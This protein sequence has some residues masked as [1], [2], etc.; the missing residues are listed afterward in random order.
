MSPTKRRA[1]TSIQSIQR[2]VAIL[3][4]FT[5]TAPELGVTPLS[6]QLGL[7]KS[8]VSRLLSALKHEGFVEQNPDTGKYRLS[9]GLVSLAGAALSHMDLRRAA[10]PHLTCLAALTQE[11][12]N[13][14][15]LEG[16]GCVNIDGIAS[17]KLI[18]YV[19]GLGRRT[20]LHCTAAGKVLLAH[21]TPEER[22]AILP[23]T[24]PRFTEK[25][26]TDYD[27]LESCLAE[28]RRQGYAI[29]HEELEEGL[30]SVAAPIHDHTGRVIATVGVSG[31][32]YRM[33]PGKIEQFVEPVKETA[34]DISARLGCVAGPGNGAK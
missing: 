19:T 26:V 23:E 1:D 20:Q 17:P 13:I 31:P 9:V 11:T 27:T 2:A 22:V 3:R 29:T 14:S 18:R 16:D 34:C 24:L 33:G 6:A 21:L 5:E 8:T 7:H 32:S 12:V 25:T 28:V 30:S 4:C 15:V 10:Q